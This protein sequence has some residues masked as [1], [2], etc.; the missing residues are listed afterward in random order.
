MTIHSV[1]IDFGGVIVRTEDKEPRRLQAEKLGLTSR[2]L[3]KI[4][5]ESESSQRASTGEITEDDHWQAVAESLAVTRAEVDKITAEFFSGD[6]ADI[7]LIDFLRSLR[8]ER[9]VCL[10]SNAWSGLRTF[11][12]R[13]K[14][15]DVFD[16]MVISAE[17]GLIKPDPRIYRLALAKLGARPEESVF[18]DDVPANVDAARSAGMVGIEFAQPEK[19]L[20]ELKQ[21][22]N[23]HR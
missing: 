2:D 23:N 22:L 11:I 7:S 17:V 14:L 4:I 3:E 16:A 19:V 12:T 13:Q 1:F 9:K 6:R 21:I 18:I 20:E 10:I 5:F 8:P 15:D